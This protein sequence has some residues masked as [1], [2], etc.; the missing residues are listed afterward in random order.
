MN[1]RILHYSLINHHFHHQ[2]KNQHKQ[3]W[4]ELLWG[5]F[6]WKKLFEIPRQKGKFRGSAGNSDM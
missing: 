1:L 4:T 6:Q 2:T 5:H 3:T